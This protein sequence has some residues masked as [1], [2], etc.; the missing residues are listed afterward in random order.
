MAMRHPRGIVLAGAFLALA[1]MSI[2]SAVLGHILPALLP[3]RYTT[4]AAAC[5]FFVFGAMMLREGL[6]MQAG[7]EKIQEELREVQKE[8]EEAEEKQSSTVSTAKRLE[9]AEEG[10]VVSPVAPV[11]ISK[12]TVLGARD[13]LTHRRTRGNDS[14][15]KEAKEGVRNLLQLFIHPVLLQTF[16]MTFLAEWG[17]RSQI[18]TIALAAAH[19]VY[20]VTIG[21]IAGHFVCTTAAVLGGRF[22]AT[23]ISV[24]NVTLA[25][26]ILFLI[27]GVAYVYEATQAG[28]YVG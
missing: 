14:S 16:I 13:S 15:T 11:S 19:N 25:G 3:R 18:S 9:E 26:S 20:I 12:D 7:N 8:V 17:D 21:T 6:E 5:L 27:F 4:I 10:N 22:L 2:L 28:V 1:V 24:K 23:K